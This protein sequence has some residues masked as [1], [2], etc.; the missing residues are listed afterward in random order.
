MR[1]MFSRCTCP[2]AGLALAALAS[3]AQAQYVVVD[4]GGV[5]D[6]K[7]GAIL[8]AEQKIVVPE[9]GWLRLIGRDVKPVLLTGPLQGR[10]SALVG[11]AG[12]AKIGASVLHHLA[13]VLTQPFAVRGS[14]ADDGDYAAI[15]LLNAG[16]QCALGSNVLL[17]RPHASGVATVELALPATRQRANL[18][19]EAARPTWPWP[20]ALDLV[21]GAQ[22]EVDVTSI[23]RNGELRRSST[24]LTLAVRPG[25]APGDSAAALTAL[26]DAGCN[27]QALRLVRTL[28]D[29][30]A[31]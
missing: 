2:L 22:Y 31:K 28:A 25:V 21:D 12:A 13:A 14:A 1:S 30:S 24:Q 26:A 29:G 5:A 19:W 20:T 11:T 23:V 6:I 17:K 9:R 7:A 16:R 15:D 27:A 4:T 3:H 18:R 10:T 8:A